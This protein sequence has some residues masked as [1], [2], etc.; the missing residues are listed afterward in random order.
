MDESLIELLKSKDESTRNEAVER[1]AGEID[2]DL[3]DAL[4]DLAGNDEGEDIRAD[5]L[6][7]L[8]PAV[9]LAGDEYGF[10]DED[11]DPD[12]FTQPPLTR[13]G[14]RHVVER[15]RALYEDTSQPTIV[16]R[17]AFEVLVRDPQPWHRETVRSL[18]QSGDRDWMLT[19]IFAMGQMAGF[20]AE[21]IEAVKTQEDDSLLEAVRAA[22]RQGVREAAPKIGDLARS[23][24]TEIELRI[25]AILALPGVDQAS[26]EILDALLDHSDAEIAAAASDA[27]DEMELYGGFED[28]EDEEE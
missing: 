18:A 27:L 26:G 17:R 16:R 2:D 25:A 7:A 24:D 1:I 14:F 5:A 8:G 10:L 19:A 22:G 28:D 23:E 9:E 3:A 15:L 6:M 13:E 21:I 12:A 20:D 11:G 4:L